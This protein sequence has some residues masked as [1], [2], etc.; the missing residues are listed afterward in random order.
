MNSGRYM[1]IPPGS[2]VPGALPDFRIYIL[3]SEGKYVLWALEGNSVSSGQLARLTEGGM[4]EVFV[5]LEKKFEFEQYLENNLGEILDNRFSSDDHKATIFS[6]V[7]ANVVK[8]AFE[9]S[10]GLGTMN[11]DALLRTQ[12]MVKNALMFISES[13][14]LQALAKM[15]GHDYQTYEHATKV[16]WLTM[17]F[18]RENPDII[19]RIQPGYQASGEKQRTE[20]LKQCGVGALL[21]DIGK[22]FVAPE[23]LNKREPLSDVEWE[24][25]KRHPLNG[26]AMLLDTDLPEFVKKAVL[27]HHEDFRGGGYPMSLEGLNITTLARVL[28]IVDAFDAMTSRRPYKDPMPPRKTMQ[29][30]IG[31]PPDGQGD[32]DPPQDS[33]DEGMRRCFDD[34]LL[35]KFVVFLGR[36]ELNG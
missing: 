18:L 11:A 4:K 12:R 34:E 5:D 24:I 32:A 13:R 25:M 31:T 10:L 30:M 22:A 17:A 3:T 14:S 7:S 27:H 16:L 28:R 2:I 19:E 1:A 20:T 8:T 23:I 26:V 33:R 21:H 35:R 15:I 36:V 9:T 29:I 6:N